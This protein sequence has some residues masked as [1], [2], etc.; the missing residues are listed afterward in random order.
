MPDMQ[1]EIA[2]GITPQLES[3][4]ARMRRPRA[5]MAALGKELEVQLRAHFAAKEKQG[6][7]KKWPDRHFWAGVRSATALT[8]V[9]DNSA[10]VTIAS[11]AFA[12]KI[13]GGPINAPP[14]KALA[15]PLTPEA[16]SVDRARLFPRPLTLVCRPGKPPLLVETGKIGKSKQWKIQYV[17]VKSVDQDADPDAMPRQ[18]D[19]ETALLARGE[20]VVAQETASLK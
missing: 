1:I 5:L 14:G 3:L 20:K 15:I 10:T 17:L 7:K 2:D 16:Y 12:H 11:P 8:D 13:T 18:A 19:L 4:S 6:N 9:T